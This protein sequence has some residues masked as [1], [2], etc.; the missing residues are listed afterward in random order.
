LAESLLQERALQLRMHRVDDLPVFRWKSPLQQAVQ[1]LKRHRDIMFADSADSQP[2]S[3]I[4][5]TLAGRS[6]GGQRN[7]GEALRHVLS[8][9][10]TFVNSTTPRVANPVN[11]AEDFADKWA[12]AAFRHLKLE[13]NFWRW[14]QKAKVDFGFLDGNSDIR[15]LA[16]HINKSVGTRFGVNDLGA[17]LGVSAASGLLQ[18]AVVPSTLSFPNK[19][20]VPS[21][22]AGFA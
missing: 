6:Y 18:P 7:V 16:E 2:I 17:T 21:K 20:L 8:T 12:D 13:E 11:P 4:L 22:P 15:T 10:G 19:P 9:M 5:T 14:L 3:V 1:I